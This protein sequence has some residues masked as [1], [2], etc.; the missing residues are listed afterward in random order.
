MEELKEGWKRVELGEVSSFLSGYAF[1]GSLFC[2]EGH[3]VIKIKNVKG[4]FVDINYTEKYPKE[5]CEKLTKYKIKNNDI[6]VA[7]TGA[8]SVGRVSKF[9]YKGNDSFYINQ[10]VGKISIDLEKANSEFVFQVISTPKYEKILFDMANGSGQ[11]NLSPKLISELEINIPPL[12]TQEKIA[13]ILSSLDDKIELNNEMN[14]TLEE[15]AQNLFKR[16]FIDFEFP[17]ENGEPYR[18]SGGKM[19]ESELG[20]IPEGWEVDIIKKIGDVITGKTPSTKNK[21][22][23]GGNIPF[24]T[25][26]D[27]HGNIFITNTERALSEIGN[28]VQSKKILPINSIMVSCIATVGLVSLNTKPSHTNQQINSIVPQNESTLFYFFNVIKTL[29][30]KLKMIGSAGTTTLNV[31][32]SVFENIKIVFPNLK[33]METYNNFVENMYLKIKENQLEIQSLTQIRDTLLP[34]LM[35]GEVEV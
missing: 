28:S 30:D 20:E 29:E 35:S 26:P 2:E 34:K 7:M 3:K 5:L 9:K 19:V 33:I 16:W 25:I 17:N 18:S 13:S 15:M 10:R 12:E 31:N 6:L 4:K 14:K 32:K 8:G 23:Y 21:E 11:P 22:N 1:K 24:I 27:M